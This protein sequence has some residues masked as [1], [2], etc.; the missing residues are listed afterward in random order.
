MGRARMSLRNVRSELSVWFVVAC[1]GLLLASQ[2]CLGES[3]DIELDAKANK[4]H[5]IDSLNLLLY[6][7]LLTLTV[8]TIWLFKHRRVSWLHETGLAVIYV[9]ESLPEADS[10]FRV[11]SLATTT[12]LL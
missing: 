7:F 4:I 2:G 8:L 12:K 5:Q 11:S 10:A 6:T 9:R 1:G 3:T